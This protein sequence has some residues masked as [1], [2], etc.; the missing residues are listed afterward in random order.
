MR[1]QPH[2]A[3]GRGSYADYLAT[4]PGQL[5]TTLKRKS[6]KVDIELFSHFDEAAWAAYEEIY[7]ASWKPA[8]GSPAFLRRFAREEAE[9][10]RLR[11]GIARDGA[12]EG[13]REAA[14]EGAT[15]GRAIAAQVWTVEG[16]TAY[17]H[18]LAH[19]EDARALSP[20]TVLSAALFEQ[21]I[22]RDRVALVDFGTGDDPYKRDW[23]EEC[24]LRYR[25]DM[26]RPG[27]LSLWPQIIKASAKRLARAVCHG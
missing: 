18:K 1:H 26:M 9:A 13:A 19:V 4:R 15:P 22:D 20:G 7:K 8:E 6:G 2:P 21:V 23:M 14:R 25:L 16:G 17:I 24:R 5:R 12:R 27:P 11:L 3:G 10:G